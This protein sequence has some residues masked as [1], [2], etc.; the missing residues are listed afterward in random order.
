[1][2]LENRKSPFTVLHCWKTE[3]NKCNAK[4]LLGSQGLAPAHRPRHHLPLSFSEKASGGEDKIKS[5]SFLPIGK[6]SAENGKRNLVN[7]L[8]CEFDF[9]TRSKGGG[10]FGRCRS[11]RM[12]TL[13][14]LFCILLKFGENQNTKTKRRHSER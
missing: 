2:I 14:C 7:S 3:C 6:Q 8:F 1:M 4:R 12:T 10:F 9:F 11:L 13:H 5:G